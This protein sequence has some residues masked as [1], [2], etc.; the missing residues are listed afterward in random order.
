MHLQNTRNAFFFFFFSENIPIQ[1]IHDYVFN[2][3]NMKKY[4]SVQWDLDL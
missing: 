1:D 4:Y 2:W 3:S